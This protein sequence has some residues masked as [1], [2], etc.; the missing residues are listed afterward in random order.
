MPWRGPEEPGEFP[1]MGWVALD[2]IEDNL[3]LPDGPRMGQPFEFYDEQGQHV[4]NRYR[5]DPEGRPEDG[6]DAYR[7]GGSMLVRGQKWGKDPILAALDLFEAFGPCDFDGWDADGNPVGKP[8]PSPWIFVAALNAEQT[9]NTWLPLK[10]ML[11]M[12]DLCNLAGVEI[13][14][15][16]VT[17]PCG[18]YI[19]KLTTTA[20]GRLGGRFTSGSLT[21]NG[22]MTDTRTDGVGGD[23][24][25]SPLQFAETLIRSVDGM[26]GRW[27]AATN[28]W[29]PTELSHAQ[30]V[31]E[32][33]DPHIYVDAKI[34]RKKVDL[35]NDDEL[36]DEII[37]LYGDSIRERG[38]HQSVQRLMRACRDNSKG[39]ARR[40]RFFLS[41]IL[42]GESPLATPER[43]ASLNRG[44]T[45]AD[46]RP[47]EA[48]ENITL[49]FDGS[50]S[51]DATV[52]TATRISDGRIFHL[53]TW[54]PSC[55]CESPDH[56]P[57]KCLEPRIARNEVDQAVTDAFEGY[58]VWYLFGDP[59]KWQEYLA[60][61]AAKWP[62]R[63]IEV[64][65]NVES[66]MDQM[67][68]LWVE[69]RD[70]GEYTHDGNADLTEHVRNAA[71]ADGRRKA[72][73]PRVD[74]T[75]KVIEHYQKVVKKGDGLIDG[76]ISMLLSLLARAKAIE[77]G[78]VNEP[79]EPPPAP[80]PA[81]RAARKRS[82]N[83]LPDLNTT[84]F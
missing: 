78:A 50:R 43:W 22:L 21:E 65:T 57:E 82:R 9:D 11:E 2:W 53:R 3:V 55:Q 17:L 74:S 62:N 69:G 61:W 77:D 64:P 37:Y 20:F 16:R 51:R 81:K 31:Y 12:S 35:A 49:G 84:G 48:G 83:G 60:L 66:R 28:T 80:R 56:R 25:R 44:P 1:T 75:G 54:L 23:G 14:Q 13:T 26:G 5:I 7:F 72:T 68:A 40:R 79:T 67:V 71:I 39:E 30:R 45:H 47:L 59:Y 15:D 6:N 4:L 24:K 46:Y 73:K 58:E 18:N 34:S 52:L 33:K 29:D 27:Q 70:R 8:H 38:G 10:A 41:E 76:A 42:A 19:E 36:R 63:V 32:A